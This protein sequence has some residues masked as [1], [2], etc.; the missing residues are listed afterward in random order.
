MINIGVFLETVGSNGGI[1]QYSMMLMNAL[2]NI[3]NSQINYIGICVTDDWVSYCRKNN[4]QY[5]IPQNKFFDENIVLRYYHSYVDC[6]HD[7]VVNKID[8]LDCIKNNIDICIFTKPSQVVYLIN[9]KVKVICPIHD[10]MDVYEPKFREVGSFWEK[11]ARRIINHR[12]VKYSK[13]IL[14]DSNLG[15]KHVE[16]VF[17][18][19][20]S[21]SKVKELAYIAPD[22]VYDWEN[23]DE[24]SDWENIR[25]RIPQKY[26]FYPA[27][28]WSHKN[29]LGILKALSQLK[30]RYNDMC[31]VFSGAP[32]NA[33]SKVIKYINVNGLQDNVIVFDYV[34]N[35]SM[36][37]LYQ[38][39]VGL[40]M[41]SFF[42]PT[43]IP[44]LEAFYLGCPV[45]VANI[46]GIPEQ[47]GDAALLFDPYDASDIARCMEVLWTSSDARNDL[48]EK[49]HIKAKKWN[50]NS[51]SDRLE[52][53]ILEVYNG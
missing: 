20:I 39:A 49:G 18:N 41:P 25:Y 31:V 48:I 8:Y 1:H 11:T 26:I 3:S 30:T 43:N 46:Y 24:E 53:I 16:E 47:V 45:A 42:G 44:Q 12:I 51:F 34:S 19:G 4:I 21:T 14:V 13:C 50:R 37:K 23:L 32:K 27:Q 6:I 9:P 2:H 29:H 52:K 10:L 5:Y 22:Y 40:V 28:F 35:Y 7:S 38:N 17:L 33:Y 15:K 36:V